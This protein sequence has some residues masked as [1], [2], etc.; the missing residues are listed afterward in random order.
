MTEMLLERAKRD[1]MHKIQ[2]SAVADNLP[3][4]RLYEK[5]GFKVE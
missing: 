4:I 5:R 2:L 1:R 3:A